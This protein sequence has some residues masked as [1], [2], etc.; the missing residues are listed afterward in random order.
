[1]EG[2]T[3]GGGWGNLLISFTT[4]GTR[5]ISR[6]ISNLTHSF[7]LQPTIDSCLNFETALA[8]CHNMQKQS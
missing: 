4:P 7:F 8:S 2:S 3:E 5:Q 6:Q 1:M